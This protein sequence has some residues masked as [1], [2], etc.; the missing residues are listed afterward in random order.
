[1]AQ[2]IQTESPPAAVDYFC[3]IGNHGHVGRLRPKVST[4][5][6]RDDRVVCRTARGIEIG[7]V[8]S[9]ANAVEETTLDG[10]VLR[11]MTPEDELL[12]RN[13]SA[14]SQEVQ[15]ECQQWLTDHGYSDILLD[16]EPLMD[17]Q[18]LYFHFVGEP[19]PI[20]S[21]HITALAELYEKRVRE[22]RFAQLLETGCGPGCGTE[23]KGGCGT[24]GGCAVCV[25]ASACKKK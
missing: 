13:L 2:S 6:E 14:M 16:V 1:M 8:L 22:S 18:T 12:W 3:R 10:A 11:R 4:R 5:F 25:V 24:G 7:E 19:S 15:S 17:G 20:V 21:E 9:M 23:A